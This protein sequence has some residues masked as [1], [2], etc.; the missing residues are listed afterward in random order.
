MPIACGERK[1]NDFGLFDMHGNVAEWCQDLY[2]ASI[3]ESTAWL[4]QGLD[5]DQLRVHRGGSFQDSVHQIRSAARDK[6]GPATRE[7][8]IGFRVARSYP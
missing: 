4:P 3:V 2:H 5:D 1:P 7:V 6:A 8:T